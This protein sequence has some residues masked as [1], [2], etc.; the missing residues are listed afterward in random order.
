LGLG[1][2]LGFGFG[3]GL[4]VFSVIRFSFFAPIVYKASAHINNTQFSFLILVI[5]LF[6]F[7]P[8][9]SQTSLALSMPM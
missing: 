6:S 8:L 3:L 7:F 4:I 1:L 5:S 2:G 9:L